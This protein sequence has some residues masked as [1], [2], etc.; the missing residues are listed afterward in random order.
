VT[1]SPDSGAKVTRDEAL[2]FVK[3]SLVLVMVLYHWLNYFV[4]VD[5]D[6]YRY[7]RFLTP[8]FIL[9]TGFLV[10]HV[11]RGKYSY[12]SPRVRR[13]LVQRG[14]KLLLLFA[15]LNLLAESVLGAHQKGIGPLATSWS[16]RAY[17]IFVTG[18]RGAAFNI[19]VPI[20]YFLLLAPGVLVLSK[21]TGVSLSAIAAVVLLVT[22]GASAEGFSNF[23]L[24]MFSVALVGLAA[25]ATE[26]SR[27]ETVLRR[28]LLLLVGY[29]LYLAAITVW[30]VRFPLQV[31]GVCLSVL[32][33]YVIGVKSG[34]DGLLQRC[35]VELGKYSL[36]SYITQIAAL[37]LLR[38]GMRGA[39]L[40]GAELIVPFAVGVVVTMVAVQIM[41]TVR[42]RST[43]ADS[44]Y[45]T[46][47]A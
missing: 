30:N 29:V 27:I 46:V 24:E 3:G 38:R 6:V 20:G 45:R 19:L 17:A 42:A 40:A 44:L 1:A 39:D 32:L 36:F 35:I 25:G 10:S 18:D 28:P 12:D 43:L 47:F 13:R 14:M 22:I 8:S 7:L 21:R 34:A 23:N 37:Q 33:I 31:I 9:I 4:T 16:A 26:F 11:Y 15:V 2:D 5:W 41:V